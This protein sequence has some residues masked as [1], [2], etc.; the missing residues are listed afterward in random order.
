MTE[1]FLAVFNMS[2]AASYVALV[3]LI[4]RILLK[5]APK[6]FS[7]ILWLAVAVRLAIPMSPT[8]DFSL[9]KLLKPE[10]KSDAEFI[11]FAPE[12]SSLMKAPVLDNGIRK[13]STVLGST[14]PGASSSNLV[15]PLQTILSISSIVWL[16]GIAVLLVYSIATYLRMHRRIRTAT[17]IKDSIYETDQVDTPFVYGFIR[18]RII[19]PTGLNTQQMSYVVMHEQ[20]HIQRKDYWIKPFAYLLLIIHWF[21][22]L[23]WLCYAQMSRDME[24]SCDERVVSRLGNSSIGGYATT[25]LSLS[26]N[27][28]PLPGHPLAFGEHHVKARI[29]NVL[30]YRKL[31]GWAVACL[32]AVITIMIAG[33]VTNPK[34]IPSAQQQTYHGYNLDTLTKNKT[35]YVGNHIKVGGLIGGMPRPDGLDGNGLELQTSSE[36]YGVTYRYLA[37]STYSE[38]D[39][40]HS[41]FY[42][43]AVLLMSLIDNVGSITY[44]ISEDSVQPVSITFTREQINELLGEDVRT[45]A[46]DEAGLKRLIDRLGEWAVN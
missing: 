41:I 2:I 39:A 42:N 11:S 27:H 36:P 1:L 18:P 6:G 25:L 15:N 24:M 32:L 26:I 45:Y 40:N 33:C 9:L 38:T 44:T 43:N 20:V 22:P 23:M 7:Y 35:L 16:A 29:R 21:N 34:A 5:R 13:I 3:I 10:S 14:L 4:L 31:P 8:S 30:A 17:L 46:A 28:K 37:T 19:V 12:V